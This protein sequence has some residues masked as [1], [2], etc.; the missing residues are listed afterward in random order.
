[1]DNIVE[2]DASASQLYGVMAF[3]V[4]RNQVPPHIS[5]RQ[6]ITAMCGVL[7]MAPLPTGIALVHLLPFGPRA[8]D[9]GVNLSQISADYLGKFTSMSASWMG[10]ARQLDIPLPAVRGRLLTAIRVYNFPQ[11]CHPPW[12]STATNGS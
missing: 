6:F 5:N 12:R 1:M 11:T 10:L 9:F 8:F 3:L 4:W 2:Y 7:V